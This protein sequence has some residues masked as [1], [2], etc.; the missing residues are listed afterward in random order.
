LGA[1]GSGI[2]V[3]AVEEGGDERDRVRV[4]LRVVAEEDRVD[5]L[6]VVAFYP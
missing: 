3:V 1:A 5:D 6:G 4:D 2:D